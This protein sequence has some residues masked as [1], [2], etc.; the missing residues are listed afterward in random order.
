MKNKKANSYV[1]I[2]VIVLF[3]LLIG[4]IFLIYNLKPVEA[5]IENNE[6]KSQKSSDFN[7]KVDEDCE[8]GNKCTLETCTGGVCIISDV[9]L[10]YDNDGCCPK[11][12]NSANDND[13]LRVD[14]ED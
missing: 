11:N 2:G 6:N 14:L 1:I 12:C 3:I 13:C 4:G 10:C 7:C 8:D 5:E 9:A